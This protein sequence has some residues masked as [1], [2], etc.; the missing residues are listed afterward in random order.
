MQNY[1]SLSLFFAAQ[2]AFLTPGEVANPEKSIAKAFDWCQEEM[3]CFH[4]TETL[5]EYGFMTQ[6]FNYLIFLD[7]WLMLTTMQAAL[8][9]IIPIIPLQRSEFIFIIL[10]LPLSNTILI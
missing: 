9:K 1:N 5:Y 10:F 3:K 6:H 8:K 7:K 2:L 4:H